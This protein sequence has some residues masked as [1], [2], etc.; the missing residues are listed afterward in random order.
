MKIRLKNIE[1]NAVNL[2]NVRIAVSS[3]LP[4]CY[5]DDN[6]DETIVREINIENGIRISR[7]S[8]TII[9]LQGRIG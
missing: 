1:S 5:P 7:K 2:A 9:V 8:A 6:S 3:S 4:P